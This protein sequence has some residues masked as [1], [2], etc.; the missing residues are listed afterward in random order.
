MQ[1]KRQA[2][3]KENLIN[4]IRTFSNMYFFF[5]NIDI[6]IYGHVTK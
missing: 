2:K 5:N 4:E 3:K 6:Y 1:L